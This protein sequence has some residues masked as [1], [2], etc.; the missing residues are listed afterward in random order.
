M[1]AGLKNPAFLRIWMGAPVFREIFEENAGFAHKQARFENFDKLLR[2]FG[3]AA[4]G[5]GGFEGEIGLEKMH[6]RVLPL[7]PVV[8]RRPVI[9][10]AMRR[11][12]QRRV[13]ES[14]CLIGP[15]NQTSVAIK[16]IEPS[17]GEKDKSVGIG[18]AVVRD[19]TIFGADREGESPFWAGSVAKFID[20]RGHGNFGEAP[21]FRK[22]A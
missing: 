5:N 20:E 8:N 13:D 4:S 10:A 7:V 9:E 11:I 21:A 19:E 12:L 16:A 15:D 6:M 3:V 2:A 18:V 14:D 17:D 22:P 1:V